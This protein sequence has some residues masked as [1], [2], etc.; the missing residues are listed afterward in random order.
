M[1]KVIVTGSNRGLG[2]QIVKGLK[3]CHV[4]LAVRD[5]NKGLEA[6]EGLKGSFDVMTLD[7]TNIDSINAFVS[8]VIKKYGW[9][10]VLINN[11]GIYNNEFS[12]INFL[13]VDYDH[14]WLTNTLGPYVLSKKLLGHVDRMVFMN[15]VAGHGI[16][17][18]MKTLYGSSPKKSYSQSK[19]GCILL[20]RYFMD[21]VDVV[22]AHP[23]YSHTDIFEGR[24]PGSV[25]DIIRF[26]TRLLAQSPSI[27]AKGA[28]NG[29]IGEYNEGEYL[30]PKYLKQ[31]YGPPKRVL[32]KDYYSDDDFNK[33]KIFLEQIY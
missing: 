25:R 15:S 31:L 26:G 24:K 22:G 28:I 27:G 19:Y 11:V 3:N 4:I 23:G 7:V 21:Y 6:I 30:V 29:A 14:V 13:G 18:D 33:F 17:L 16:K 9:V 8:A 10:D 5:V 20:T 1:K 2:L 12:V 32:L